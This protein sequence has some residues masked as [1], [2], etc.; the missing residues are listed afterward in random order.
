M[1][2]KHGEH[3]QGGMSTYVGVLFGDSQ[4][5]AGIHVCRGRSPDRMR[6]VMKGTNVRG[7]TVMVGYNMTTK[8]ARKL[9]DFLNE[10][11][12]GKGDTRSALGTPPTPPEE[13]AEAPRQLKGSDDES[14]E[15]T[16]PRTE[17]E[18]P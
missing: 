18:T 15:E 6:I 9:R 1:G 7:D 17:A 3:F 12:P 10:I 14:A 13:V 5:H 2:G 11:L 4:Q 16:E 8:E